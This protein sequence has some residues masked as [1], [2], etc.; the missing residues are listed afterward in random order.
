MKSHGNKILKSRLRWTALPLLIILIFMALNLECLSYLARAGCEQFS[1]MWKRQDFEEVIG[2]PQTTDALRNKLRHVLSVRQYAHEHLGLNLSNSYTQYSD[3]NRNAAAWNVTASREL[4]FEPKTW[5]FPIVGTVPYLGYFSEN[6]AQDKANELKKDGWETLVQEVS[7]YS[8]L[9]WFDD[10]L[11]SS[12][13]GLPDWYLTG[14]VI[15]ESAHA[16]IWFPGDVDFNE[17]FASFVEKQGTRRYYGE[18]DRALLEK[19]EISQK[20]YSVVSETF[21]RFAAR[22]D[23]LYKSNRTDAD[24]RN[25]KKSL[26]DEMKNELLARKSEFKYINAEAYAKREYNNA[27]FLAFLRYE[28]GQDYFQKSFDDCRQNWA[29]FLAR[30]QALKDKSPEERKALLSK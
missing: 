20:E 28:S 17:S 19:L 22:L 15:H 9:G 26:I 2:N 21:R 8:T 30:M 11:L 3:I 25:E 5:W 12:Q 27:S 23:E 16:T 10:P 29:C 13:I 4:I 7:A 14:L 18:N 24:K 6:L 1:I